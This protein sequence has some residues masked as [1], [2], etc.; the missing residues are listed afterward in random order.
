[1]FFVF[2]SW[3]MHVTLRAVIAANMLCLEYCDRICDARYRGSSLNASLLL[4]AAL[5]GVIC[6]TILLGGV[7]WVLRLSSN[8]RCLMYRASSEFVSSWRYRCFF[9]YDDRAIIVVV[10]M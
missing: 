1:M 9:V 10:M 6:T 2:M 5:I 3:L 8:T 7:A 4:F